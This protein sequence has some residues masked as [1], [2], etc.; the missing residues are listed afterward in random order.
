MEIRHLRYFVTTAEELHFTRAAKR[1]GIAQPP[2][3]QQIQQLEREVGTQLFHRLSRGVELTEAGKS[4]WQD[5]R[6]ILDQ[7]DR[8]RA[9]AQ[10]VARGERGSIRIGFTSSASFN[11]FVPAVISE[12]RQKHRNVELSLGENTTSVLLEQLREGRLDFAFLRPAMGET[13]AM[14]T[15]LLFE[16]DMCVALP[17]PHPLVASPKIRLVALAN[18]PFIMYPRANGRAL[19]DTIIAGCRNAGFSPNIG[20]EAPQMASTVNLV[21]A[22]IGVAIVPASMRQLQSQGVTYRQIDGAPIKAALSLTYRD[23][24]LSAAMTEFLSTVVRAVT[25]RER[26]IS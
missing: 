1:L 2:L 18:E 24:P 3:S 14:R 26:D 21:A 11:P 5:A 12:Y 13:G 17:A 10:A 4:F 25:R 16:E 9:A 22:G 8:A 15:R 6:A 19:Y 20:Q 23:D 7:I